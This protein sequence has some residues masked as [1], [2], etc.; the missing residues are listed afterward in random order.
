[1]IVTFSKMALF[2]NIVNFIH[3]NDVSWL[4]APPYH[5]LPGDIF[6][7]NRKTEYLQL[8]N[9]YR[10]LPINSKMLCLRINVKNLHGIGIQIRNTATLI[11]FIPFLFTTFVASF[12]T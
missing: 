1:M 5:P 11:S 12:N 8:Q 9:V 10:K 3:V 4:Y 2:F 7:E 6:E